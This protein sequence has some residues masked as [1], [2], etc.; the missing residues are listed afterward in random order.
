MLNKWDIRTVIR[1]M[2]TLFYYRSFPRSYIL[3]PAWLLITPAAI[4]V[5]SFV[6]PAYRLIPEA[7]VHA[8]VEDAIDAYP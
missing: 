1:L 7:T 8:L 4:E 2:S 6:T 3:F 5:G